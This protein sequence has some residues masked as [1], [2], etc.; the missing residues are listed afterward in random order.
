MSLPLFR[1]SLKTRLLTDLSELQYVC[2][3]SKYHLISHFSHSFIEKSTT[4][5]YNSLLMKKTR[6]RFAP[7]PS[8]FLHIGGARTALFN[9]LYA[10][11][12]NGEFILR[13]EDTDR[14]RSDIKSVKAILSSLK[15]L[16]LDWDEGPQVGGEYGPYFQSERREIYREFAEKLLN[17]NKAYRCFC[18]PED[19]KRRRERAQME[20]KPFR[21]D[22]RCLKLSESEVD[23]N[24]SRDVPYALRLNIPD[25]GETTFLDLI[26]GRMEFKNIELE[27]IIILRSDK[28]PTYNFA[29]VVDDYLMNI[30]HIIRGDDHLSNTPKQLWVYGAL[31]ADIPEFAHVPLILG[32][33]RKR[34]SKRHGA[35]SVSVYEEEG[36]LPEAVF[37]YISLLGWSPGDDREKMSR[38][39]IISAF[40]IDGISKSSSVFDVEKLEWLNGLYIREKDNDEILPLL[41][42]QLI[43]AGVDEEVLETD[44]GREV[45]LVE[46]DKLK[47]LSDIVSLTSYFFKDDYPYEEKGLKK[48]ILKEPKLNILKELL[49]KLKD[50]EQF[51]K[52]SIEA[53]IRGL[54]DEMDISAGKVIHPTRMALTGR[55]YGPGLFELMELLGREKCI[56]RI[57]RTID[58]FEPVLE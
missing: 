34:L 15:W 33:D 26:R 8:G 31:D 50:E 48:H 22:K 1:F 37:N 30:S 56:E 16:G 54:A 29:V 12:M 7:S 49:K 42:E 39:E 2:K 52:E 28:T 3:L 14:E 13:V 55:T 11:K 58:K 57:E 51:D 4:L 17:E 53:H 18:A 23:E 38:E 46:V 10:K 40:S 20:G 27:D 5:Y 24:L 32:P 44:W 9:Y 43:N 47:K 35:T 19:L 21:Y 36:Y 41:K 6:V 25:E 45:M